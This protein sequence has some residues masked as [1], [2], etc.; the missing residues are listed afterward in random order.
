MP[1][2]AVFRTLSRDDLDLKSPFGATTLLEL[3]S[4]FFSL[5]EPREIAL[6]HSPKSAP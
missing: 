3:L 5:V 2:L 1:T 4:I 6:V